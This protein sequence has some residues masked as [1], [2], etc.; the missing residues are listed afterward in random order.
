[1]AAAAALLGLMFLSDYFGVSGKRGWEPLPSE[2]HTAPLPEDVC[3][4]LTH[5][6]RTHLKRQRS[7]LEQ[8]RPTAR[9]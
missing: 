8:T 1:M 9:T 2:L 3:L 5:P 7:Y 4:L 6:L